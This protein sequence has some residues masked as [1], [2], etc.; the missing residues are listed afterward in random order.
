[1]QP[2]LNGQP[3]PMHM[4]IAIKAGDVLEMGMAISGLRSYISFYGGLDIPPIM[5]SRSTSL[6]C[7][8]GGWQGRALQKG[9]I[10]PTAASNAQIG[11]LQQRL[12]AI[13]QALMELSEAYQLWKF[14]GIRRFT[15]QVSTP[16][17]RVVPGPQTEAFSAEGL[18]SFAREN[19]QVSSSSNRMACKLE[20]PLIK[21]PKGSDIISDGIV[22]GSIQVSSSGM[23]IVML[24]D[25]QTTGGYAKIGTVIRVDIPLAA[26]ARPGE[27]LSFR[28]TTPEEGIRA[29]RE[30]AKAFLH[31]KE[32]IGL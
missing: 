32:R 30:E 16:V 2:L 13:H 19:Y 18:H 24:A 17:L 8:M 1:M 7:G 4:P 23:P 21:M 5:G 26:Q 10:I 25:H 20:G 11:Q 9:D 3:V 14:Q 28:F 31:I 27:T 12:P 22:E 15:R 29:C 6:S